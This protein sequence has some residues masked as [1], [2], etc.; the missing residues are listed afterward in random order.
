MWFFEP[1]PSPE[2]TLTSS[3]AFLHA[4]TYTAGR[5]G[6]IEIKNQYFGC[7]EETN[8]TYIFYFSPFFFII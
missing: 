2:T 8:M 4:G 1:I 5:K 6:W 7:L 3:F